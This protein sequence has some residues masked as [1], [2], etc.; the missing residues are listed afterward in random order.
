MLIN[1]NA[2]EQL[3]SSSINLIANASN[4]DIA[5]IT[6]SHD[7]TR[8]ALVEQGGKRIKI[9]DLE[10]LKLLKVLIRGRSDK[11]IT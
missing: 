3:N 10:T 11:N 7:S 4:Y 2:D 9:F 1:Y 8:I 6:I 5:N